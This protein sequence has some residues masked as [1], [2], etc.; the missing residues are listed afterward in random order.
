MPEESHVTHR[1]C[2]CF[3]VLTPEEVDDPDATYREVSSWVTGPKSQSPV[4]REQTGKIAHAKCINKVIDGQ[5]P[6]QEPL[7]GLEES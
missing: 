7:P 1:C 5:S 4:L 2:L 6:D 3:E